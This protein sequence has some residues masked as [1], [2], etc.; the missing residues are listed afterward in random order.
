MV[1]GHV[2]PQGLGTQVPFPGGNV[3]DARVH[4]RQ[5]EIKKLLN[6]TYLRYEE[7]K[8]MHEQYIRTH[9]RYDP[10]EQRTR[11]YD[12]DGIGLDPAATVF[13]KKAAVDHC[14]Q[15]SRDRPARPKS[16]LPP[17]I[18]FCAISLLTRTRPAPPQWGC[19]SPSTRSSIRQASL[20]RS[21][22]RASQRS[23]ALTVLS[24]ASAEKTFALCPRGCDT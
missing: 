21:S 23:S 24:P 3:F 13:G 11:G 22:A 5:G 2:L 10:G 15:R 19:A 8:E 17:P 12:W 9:G 6:P 14:A 16:A 20:R 1:R 18:E 7:S 4:D